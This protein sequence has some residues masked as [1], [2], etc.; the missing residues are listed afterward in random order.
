MEKK[1]IEDLIEQNLTTIQIATALHLSSTGARYWMAKHGLRVKGRRGRK[2]DPDYPEIE[3]HQH[4][5]CMC[6]EVKPRS[7]FYKKRA[8]QDHIISYCKPCHG[9]WTRDRIRRFKQDCLEYK[10][11]KCEACDYNRYAGSLEFHHLDPSQK[12]FHLGEKG[13]VTLD[14]NI[15]SELDKCALLCA[16]CHR[17]AHAGLLVPTK[18]GWILAGS[19]RIEPSSSV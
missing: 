12:D 17:E 19:D 15:K 7:D 8:G 14:E 3:S 11:G 6:K 10:G 13:R 2:Y 1:I 16:C 4:V 9:R 18:D 5:C